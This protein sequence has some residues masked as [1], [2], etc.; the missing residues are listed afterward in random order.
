MSMHILIL[1]SENMNSY[2]L[3]LLIDHS[4][5]EVDDDA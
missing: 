1:R 4:K 5:N 3:V 2:A